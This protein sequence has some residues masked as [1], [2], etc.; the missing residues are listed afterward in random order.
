MS[1]PFYTAVAEEKEN[2]TRDNLKE[3]YP[4]L[5]INIIDRAIETVSWHTLFG[6]TNR[7]NTQAALDNFKEMAI[8][9]VE[10]QKEKNVGVIE[11][12][13]LDHDKRFDERVREN[14]TELVKGIRSIPTGVLLIILKSTV[15][16]WTT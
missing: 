15:A 12:I 11:M 14:D 10:E 1:H 3:H 7:Y 2:I 8:D 16:L 4:H 6:G 9:I 5:P 13:L